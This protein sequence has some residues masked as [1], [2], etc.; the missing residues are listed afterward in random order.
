MD[1]AFEVDRDDRLGD[2][3]QGE[4]CIPRCIGSVQPA[5]QGAAGDQFQEQ[6]EPA[7]SLVHL[8]E[9]HDV[10]MP[11]SREGPRLAEPSCMIAGAAPGPLRTTFRAT[12][13]SRLGWNAW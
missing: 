7:I 12:R 9:G 8:V 13:R 11:H 4:G 2:R 6:V 1:Q 3:Q 5:F 10:G